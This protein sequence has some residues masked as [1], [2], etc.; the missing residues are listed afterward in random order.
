MTLSFPY[1][2]TSNCWKLRLTQLCLP[3]SVVGCLGSMLLEGRGNSCLH[4]VP[5]HI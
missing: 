1:T 4:V 5:D 2:P 3:W